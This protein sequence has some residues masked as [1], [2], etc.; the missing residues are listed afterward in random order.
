MGK[1]ILYIGNK[2]SSSKTNPT[3]HATLEE[4]LKA[5]GYK[6]I[7]ASPLRN[8]ILRLS[9]MVLV[10]FRNYRRTDYVLIDVYSTQNFWYAVL[11]ARLSAAFSKKYIPILHGGALKNRFSR[12][13]QATEKLL[14]NALYIISPS[15]YLKEE[16]EKL[17]YINVKY[18][19]NPLFLQK[20][21][22]RERENFQPNLLWVRAFDE[23]Y[24]PLLALKALIIL[25]KKY[26][27]AKLCMVGPDKDGSLESCKKFAR[28]NDLNVSFPGKLKKSEWANI[29]VNY[30]LFINSSNIDNTPVS[31]IEAMALGLPVVSTNVGGLPYLIED[32]VCGI[33]V[34]ANDAEAMA[35]S[36]ARIIEKPAAAKAMAECGRRKIK[37][38]DWQLIKQEWHEVLV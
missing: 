37:E 21:Q 38:F 26:P 12:S 24:N 7:S 32:E 2:L 25:Q 33:L 22:F 9:H 14:R 10:F 35:E 19:P 5:E 4:G 34:P 30:D 27:G 1:T 20:Y 18:I 28:K 13:P 36:V 31:V 8:K 16:V 29:S 23:I 15:H 17:G 3:T 6:V 11:L